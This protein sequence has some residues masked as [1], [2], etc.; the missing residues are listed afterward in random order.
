MPTPAEPDVALPPAPGPLVLEGVDHAYVE[1]R[2]VLAS[3]SVTI[4]PGERVALVGATGA[5]KTTLGAIAA[6]VLPASSGSVRLAG[7]PLSWLPHAALR[8]R[9]ALISQ[10]FHVFAGTVREAV[11]LVDPGAP[12]S[13]VLA[14]L[15]RVNAS[16][17]VRGLPEGLDTVIGSGGHPVTPAQAQQLALA[18]IALADPWYVVLDEA[19]AEAGSAGARELEQAA[20]AVTAERGA[21]VV[22]HRLTQS[23]TADRVLV[24]HDGVVVEEGSHAEL[25]AAGGRYADLWAAWSR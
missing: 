23:A 2:P 11:T 19:T 25:L 8:S 13:A 16:A 24:L 1:G 21:L 18:R 7:V 22:A 14:A 10:D 5:G 4:N 6:G 9:V 20:L 3:V 12:D 15:E 17:W